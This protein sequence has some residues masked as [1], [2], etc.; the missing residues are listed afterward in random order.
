MKSFI[1]ILI[2]FSTLNYAQNNKVKLLFNMEGDLKNPSFLIDRPYY[3]SNSIIFEVHKD[4]VSNIYI[5]DYSAERDSFITPF[6]ITE[7]NSIN[8]NPKGHFIAGGK[9]IFFQTNLY[10]KWDIGYREYLNGKW[11]DEKIIRDPS[12]DDTN[13]SFVCGYSDSLNVVYQK[14]N[15]IYL[16][17]IKDS[18]EFN[19]LLISSSDSLKYYQPV[20]LFSQYYINNRWFQVLE[21]AALEEDKN[22]NKRII[23]WIKDFSSDYNATLIV[24]S[25]KVSNPRFLL[26]DYQFSL[27]YEKIDSGKSQIY[28]YDP[29]IHQRNNIELSYILDGNFSKL[30]TESYI[31]PVVKSLSKLNQ[32]LIFPYLY[33]YNE[34]DSNFIGISEGQYFYKDTLISTK[35]KN[36]N[37]TIAYLQFDAISN[38]EMHCAIWA[39]SNNGNIKLFILKFN[40][41]GFN[42]VSQINNLANFNLYQNYPNPFNPT[43]TIRY[44]IPKETNVTIKLYDVT[45]REIMT[46]LNTTQKA[47]QYEVE[48]NAKDY[49]SGIYF[50]Q[51][52]AGK[53]AATRKM[54]LLK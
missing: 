15:S 48:W 10:G 47:G 45:G 46:L 19:R 25:G 51:I 7:D 32:F 14:N 39:D 52:R 17:T 53:Y 20:G 11:K 41:P 2:A 18:L 40:I 26:N 6:P 44:E 38:K 3:L 16:Y 13:P 29:N 50:Y 49:A 34:N 36:V 23:E 22:K 27:V 1:L 21:I 42:A 54:L 5:S 35:I 8:I 24:D 43:T 28:N 37:S 12:N 9:M 30:Q 31:R 33:D 4:T